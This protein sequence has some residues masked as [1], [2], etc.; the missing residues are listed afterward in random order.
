MNPM[1]QRLSRRAFASGLAAGATALS[2]GSRISNVR[3]ADKTTVRLALYRTNDAWEATFKKVI[4][5]F[6]QE[7]PAI[8]VNVELRP[9]AQYWD[10]L[11][12][13]FAAGNAPDVTVNQADW[14]IP[15]AA[16]GMFI[17][18]K[19]YWDKE[20]EIL[21]DLW[22]PL[23]REWGYKGGIYGGFLYTGGQMLYIN[24]KLLQ[25][26]GLQMPSPDW[27]WNDLHAMAE[28]LTI[29]SKKQYGVHFA[30]IDPPYWSASFIHGAGGSVLNEARD[31]CT[32]N[33][34]KAREGLQF[35]Y[36][37]IHKDKFMP[38]PPLPNQTGQV[39][40]FMAGKVGIYFGGSW[41][42][43]A[44]RTS[45]F[46]WDF[47]HMPK[48]PTTGIRRVQQGS[49]AW[50]MLSSTKH[51][52]ESW[53]LIKYLG[54]PK[55]QKGIETLGIPCSKSVIDAPDFKKFH[56]PQDI[57]VPVGDFASG[58]HDYYATP[59]ASE[60]W[61]AVTQN[62][63]PMWTGEDTVESATQKAT[64]AVNKI[65]AKRKS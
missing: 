55:G 25:E 53:A 51:K 33:T 57:E 37:L 54:G 42:E 34:P 13:E 59:D 35:L 50:S 31:Q 8:T 62:F 9:G 6:E 21:S 7:N 26:A 45:G 28:K 15:G 12:T 16:R 64:D 63:T 61:N 48:H 52:D 43:V 36:D 32:L 24:K 18:L 29:P 1:K 65:F 46:D 11:Q 10:K 40:P 22:Y 49:N 27:T 47:A 30:P 20:P 56:A 39:N 60:W 4:A 19:P 58:G 14:V 23:T 41:D 2:V 44:I 17:D 5:A 3:A 38:V